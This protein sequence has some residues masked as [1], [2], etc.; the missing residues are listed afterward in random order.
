VSHPCGDEGVGVRVSRLLV[1]GVDAAE[2]VADEHDASE[3]VADVARAHAQAPD[4]LVDRAGR[5]AEGQEV[6]VRLVALARAEL[7]DGE[8]GVLLRGHVA[9]ERII[10]AVDRGHVPV[11][12]VVVCAVEGEQEG[13]VAVAALIVEVAYDFVRLA[14]RERDGEIHAVN[15]DALRRLAGEDRRGQCEED[16]DDGCEFEHRCAGGEGCPFTLMLQ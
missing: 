2:R 13:A 4:D 9:R 6:A 3:G 10:V 7:V 5:F 15:F 12:V 14:V 8:H 11:F 16:G 1:D